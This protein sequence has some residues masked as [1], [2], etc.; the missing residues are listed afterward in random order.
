MI[1]LPK[2]HVGLNMGFWEGDCPATGWLVK[3]QFPNDNYALL[4]EDGSVHSE[5]FCAEE[6][7]LPGEWRTF[8]DWIER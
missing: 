2:I 5:N 7:L 6:D 1:L 4:E 3:N 8:F